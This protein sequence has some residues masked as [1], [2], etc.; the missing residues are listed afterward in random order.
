MKNSNVITGPAMAV[1]VGLGLI[2][3]PWFTSIGLFSKVIL[4]VIGIFSFLYGVN[5]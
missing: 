2:I 3:V 4:V 5:N 1:L